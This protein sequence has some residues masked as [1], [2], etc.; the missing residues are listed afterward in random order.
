MHDLLRAYAVERAADDPEPDR[1]AALTRL[2]DHYTHTASGAAGLAYPQERDYLPR[3]PAPSTP[4]P[5]FADQ[6]EAVA[7]LEAERRNL[8]AGANHAATHGWSVHASQLSHTLA[9]H[10]R[11]RAHYT[12]AVTLHTHAPH[13]ARG[14]GGRADEG[15]TLVSFG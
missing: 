1:W 11:T 7:W 14:I 8:L 3:V 12:D 4:R 13:A 2:F 15:R 10:L 5:D 9:R 6:T